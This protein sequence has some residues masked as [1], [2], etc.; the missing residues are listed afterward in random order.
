[1]KRIA[2]LYG[3][4]AGIICGG[5]FFVLNPIG[6]DGAV[7]LNNGQLYGFAIMIVAFGLIFLGLKHYRDRL[8][9]GRITFI[10][11]LKFSLLFSLI[12]SSFY[13][14]GWEIYTAKMDPDFATQYV[15]HM[16]SE[17]RIQGMDEAAIELDLASQIDMMNQYRSNPFFRIG[18]TYSEIVPIGLIMSLVGSLIFGLILKPKSNPDLPGT[19]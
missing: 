2:L 11:A 17:L 9:G 13:V 3:S 8:L 5:M 16:R 19:N 6:S 7:S 10:Q 4:I 15:D 18:V 14:I 1:M 12:T